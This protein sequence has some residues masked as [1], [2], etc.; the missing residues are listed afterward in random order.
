[1]ARLLV[2]TPLLLL[3]VCSL[4]GGGGRMTSVCQI[5]NW[6]LV[7]EFPSREHYDRCMK[8]IGNPDTLR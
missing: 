6:G 4:T 2:G 1:M 7:T 8:Y 3:S 5:Q